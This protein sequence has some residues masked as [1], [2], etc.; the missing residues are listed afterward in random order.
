MPKILVQYRAASMVHM[1]RG[2]SWT[3]PNN[4]TAEKIS[5]G[6]ARGYAVFEIR[7]TPQLFMKSAGTSHCFHA[8]SARKNS[9]KQLYGAAVFSQSKA[10]WIPLRV[11]R[12]LAK[13]QGQVPCHPSSF[14]HLY[15]FLNF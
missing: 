4:C 7:W 15:H 10:N 3:R 14:H 13:F 9:M 5:I 2:F 11:P 8:S 1:G 6:S 12:F